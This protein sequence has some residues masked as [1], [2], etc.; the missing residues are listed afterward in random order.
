MLMTLALRCFCL[1]LTLT[2]SLSVASSVWLS[3]CALCTSPPQHSRCQSPLLMS[4][5]ATT[6]ES[7]AKLEHQHF[8]CA[9]LL[10]IFMFVLRPLPI[11]PRH[12]SLLCLRKFINNSTK[13]TKF[14]YIN[15]FI[16]FRANLFAALCI[17][18]G[19][20]PLF[21][22]FYSIYASFSAAR[23]HL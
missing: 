10:F 23:S 22:S 11:P 7:C 1:C 19:C 17:R 20:L 12:P 15:L 13:N 3:L 21:L 2:L 14:I 5:S 9:L 4:T 18:F 8:V 16:A 6:S